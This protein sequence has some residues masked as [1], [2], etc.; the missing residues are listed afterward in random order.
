[1]GTAAAGT[2]YYQVSATTLD[3]NML[4]RELAPLQK[5]GDNHPKYLLTL[6]EYMPEAKYGGILKLNAVDWLLEK[7]IR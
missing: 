5:I 3:E 2:A 1:M 6:D 4:L 7:A